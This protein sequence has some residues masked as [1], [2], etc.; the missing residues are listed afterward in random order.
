MILQSRY[1]VGPHLHAWFVSLS[2]L[3]TPKMNIQQIASEARIMQCVWH[4]NCHKSSLPTQ[5]VNIS[6]L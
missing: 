1:S 6:Q 3:L 2:K 5:S 4:L